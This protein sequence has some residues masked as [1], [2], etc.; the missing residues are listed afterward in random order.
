MDQSIMQNFCSWMRVRQYCGQKGAL[1]HVRAREPLA[2]RKSNMTLTE[3]FEKLPKL[4]E[5]AET[6]MVAKRPRPHRYAK[7]CGLG[8]K[9]TKRN[10]E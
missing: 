7:R 8:T 2:R 5:N 9:R 1:A 4:P 10:R 6:G 3:I